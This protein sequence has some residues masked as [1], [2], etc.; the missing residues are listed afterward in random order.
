MKNSKKLTILGLS[1]AT[2]LVAATGAVSSFAWFAANGSVTANDMTVKALSTTAYLQIKNSTDP[3]TT[4]DHTAA[5]AVV[6]NATLNPTHIFKTLT[7]NAGDTEDVTEEYEKGSTVQWASANSDKVTS[8]EKKGH[9]TNVS[10]IADP[11]DPNTATTYTLKNTFDLRLRPNKEGATQATAGA[12]TASV[13]FATSST[14]T[15][16]EA[17]SVFVTIGTKGMLF[18]ND[19]TDF[20][21]QGDTNLVEQMTTTAVSAKVFVFFDGENENCFT[22]NVNVDSA[23]SVNVTF[24]L[25]AKAE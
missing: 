20:T 23:Y 18:T 1:A 16:R 3:W 5:S 11:A 15:I 4:G 6:K 17:I 2:A 9:Y 22:N 10:G 14:D 21:A 13:A 12:L 7:I 25:V 24:S 8:W 19:G